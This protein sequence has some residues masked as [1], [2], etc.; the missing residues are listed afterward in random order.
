MI[1]IIGAMQQ[2]VQAVTDRMQQVREK[3]ISSIHFFEGVLAGKNVVVMQ[4]GVAKVAAALTTTV[5][6]EHYH[7]TGIVNMG[8][9][10]GLKMEQDV[11][12]AV[13]STCV[14]AHDVDVLGW[15]K[16]F[17]Q[18]KTCYQADATY[19]ELM[20]DIAMQ[21][22]NRIWIGPIASGDMFVHQANQYEKILRDFPEA[23]CAEM[24]AAAIA[25]VCQHYQV[26]FIVIRSLSDIT[27]RGDSGI[28]FEVY[29]EKASARSAFWC[30][31]FVRQ[32]NEV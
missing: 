30:E 5:L 17:D 7:P 23:L 6:M 9:A 21:S 4:S 3:T 10:G 12:D 28:A 25:Q 32:Y 22:Q 27:V 29:L 24:E 13:I 19:L 1:A 18:D 11:L 20:K 8:T 16:G 14:A 15:P 26:P 31:E 2:E